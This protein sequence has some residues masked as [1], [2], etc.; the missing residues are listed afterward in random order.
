FTPKRDYHKMLVA[1]KLLK[2]G[3]LARIAREIQGHTEESPG[4]LRF[5]MNALEDADIARALYEASR[6]G[7]RVDLLVRDSCRVR[8]G[9]PGIS[10][11]IQV[12][13]VV[14]R[15]LEHARVYYFR[16]GGAEEYWIGSA[17]AMNRN[18]ES[19][20]EVLAPVEDPTLRQE[21]RALLDTLWNDARSAW[22]MRADG[23][24]VQRAP[25][26]G[27]DGRGSHAHLI[28]LAE[29]RNREATRLRKR[30][31]TPASG[32]RNLA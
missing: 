12:V 27:A 8:P 11:N 10:D 23:T 14:G 31:S 22:D 26:K 18:L 20:V 4:H 7:V 1:A 25:Q 15:F 24:Y 16:N 13:S 3:L 2:K 32:G 6:A 19:R 17:D 29:K 5:K 30:R 9:L 28:E 21:L